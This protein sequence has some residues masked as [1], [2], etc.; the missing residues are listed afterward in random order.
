MSAPELRPT[1][2]WDIKDKAEVMSPIAKGS[3]DAAYTVAIRAM[4]YAEQQ[5]FMRA[6]Q[7]TQIVDKIVAWGIANGYTT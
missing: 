6:A 1:G 4:P 5:R 7:T 2:L 3:S